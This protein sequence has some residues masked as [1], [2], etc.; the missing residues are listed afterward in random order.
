MKDIT[1]GKFL[2]EFIGFPLDAPVSIAPF[3][4]GY[5]L[6]WYDSDEGV[7]YIDPTYKDTE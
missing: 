4:W 3:N 5:E 6:V 1:L 2:D 7:V